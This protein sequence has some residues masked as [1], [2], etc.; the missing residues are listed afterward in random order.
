MGSSPDRIGSGPCAPVTGIDTKPRAP[1]RV[2]V[3][4]LLARA[5]KAANAKGARAW[6]DR[7]VAGLAPGPFSF[8]D[9]SSR[10]D[11]DN[12]R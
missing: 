4:T 5:W 10:L 1:W 8:A 2:G 11:S 7:V 9:C 3:S 12:V 6:V